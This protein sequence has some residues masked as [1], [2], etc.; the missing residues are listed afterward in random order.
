MA[1]RDSGNVVLMSAAQAAMRDAFLGWQCRLRQLAMRQGAGRPTSGMRPLVTVQGEAQP[2]GQITVL[3]VR[4]APEQ[5]TAQFRYAVKRTLDPVE[6]WEAAVTS[7]QA[8]YFQQPGAFSDTL[9]ALFGQGSEAAE[10]LVL[11]GKAR[12]DFEQYSQRFRL[13]CTVRALAERHPFHQ[14]TY[15]HNHLFNPNMPAAV[16]VLAFQPD[17]AHAEADPPVPSVAQMRG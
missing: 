8:S 2:L 6:R 11:A 5:S 1:E 15:W 17:W 16:R 14:A 3:I 10:W 13:P 7:M 4:Q 9:T 12:L